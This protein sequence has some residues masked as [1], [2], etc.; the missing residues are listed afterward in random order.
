MKRFKCE[1][2]CQLNASYEMVVEAETALEAKQLAIREAKRFPKWQWEI[3]EVD[4]DTIQLN[5]YGL[6]DEV[7]PEAQSE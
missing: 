2:I 6:P 5:T 4:P 1:L 7:E 3:E